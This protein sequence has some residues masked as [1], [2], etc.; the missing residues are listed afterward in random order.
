MLLKVTVS[1]VAVCL[2]TDCNI[3]GDNKKKYTM[4]ILRH[5]AC[6]SHDGQ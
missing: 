1:T 3:W 2:W 5:K 4:P 6:M